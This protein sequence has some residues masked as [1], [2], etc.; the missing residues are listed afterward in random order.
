MGVGSRN[1]SKSMC[2]AVFLQSDDIY[3][4]CLVF[5]RAE[6]ERMHLLTFMKVGSPSLF[7]RLMVL[8]AQG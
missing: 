3:L 1:S 6:N 5:C 8:G 2:F 4:T 7:F